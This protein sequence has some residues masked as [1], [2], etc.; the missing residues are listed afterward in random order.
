MP[1]S[2]SPRITKDAAQ[3]VCMQTFQN[4]YEKDIKSGITQVFNSWNLVLFNHF[5]VFVI[6]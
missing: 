1:K 3:N 6:H 4:N 5:F 2:L